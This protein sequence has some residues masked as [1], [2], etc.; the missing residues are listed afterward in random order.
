MVV[1]APSAPRIVQANKPLM[2]AGAPPTV[3]PLR[4]IKGAPAVANQPVKVV[5]VSPTVLPRLPFVGAAGV[6]N[7][8]VMVVGSSVGLERERPERSRY[9]DPPV[10]S[11]L[12]YDEAPAQY[13]EP[14]ADTVAL[15]L[16][17]PPWILV[18]GAAAVLVGV[19]FILKGRKR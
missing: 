19:A 16:T 7:Q 9:D 3:L 8:P 2:V 4:P 13:V 18:A 12:R 5:G 6:A 15:G 17:A 14:A 1:G 11:P 10:P